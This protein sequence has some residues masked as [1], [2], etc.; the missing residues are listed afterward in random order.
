MNTLVANKLKTLRKQKGLSQEEVADYLHI[1]QPT[2]ARME[3]GESS[4]WASYINNICGLYNI[5]PE[6]LLKQDTNTFNQNNKEGSNNGIVINNLSEKLIEQYEQ[7]LQE[8]DTY[9]VKLETMIDKL[10]KND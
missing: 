8:K 1:S 4:S 10:L 9:I 6:E 5:A 2:Y 7:R 3:K